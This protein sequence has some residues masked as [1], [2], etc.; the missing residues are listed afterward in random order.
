MTFILPPGPR[1]PFNSALI[2]AALLVSNHRVQDRLLSSADSDGRREDASCMRPAEANVSFSLLW[3]TKTWC[4]CS[5]RFPPV[6]AIL[7]SLTTNA[8]HYSCY[9]AATT[10]AAKRRG[11]CRR[12]NLVVARRTVGGVNSL[13]CWREFLRIRPSERELELR[14]RPVAPIT[15][16]KWWG[17]GR[18]YQGC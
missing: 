4:C 8:R 6:L 15:A 1:G 16:A 9:A 18:W 2:T 5:G 17:G 10:D 14:S 11:K 3:N 7:Q 13:S 12:C